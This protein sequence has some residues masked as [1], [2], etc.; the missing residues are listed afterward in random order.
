MQKVNNTLLIV[1]LLF[2][3]CGDCLQRGSGVV[4]D[5]ETHLPIDSVMIRKV[6]EGD[7][8]RPFYS[9]KNGGFEARYI[10][11]GIFKCPDLEARIEK[12][13]YKTQQLTL[14]SDMKIELERAE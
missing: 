14:K 2:L 8:E 4:V 5:A 12:R 1:A 13:G 10:S 11:G 6:V 7:F 3:G 9:D